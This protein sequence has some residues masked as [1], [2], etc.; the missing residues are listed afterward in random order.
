MLTEKRPNRTHLK[1]P[2]PDTP[3]MRAGQVWDDRIGS[4]RVQAK[5]WR[6]AALV[7]ACGRS[8]L[9]LRSKPRHPLCYWSHGWWWGPRR[10]T[11]ARR[12]MNMQGSM[13]WRLHGWRCG[14]QAA[15][16]GRD[17]KVRTVGEWKG[18]YRRL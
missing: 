5:N 7:A 18:G 9:A 16:E 11:G 6:L 13:D 3:Y 1:T 8:R 12:S 15:A 10:G 17:E 2:E 14:V 4:A